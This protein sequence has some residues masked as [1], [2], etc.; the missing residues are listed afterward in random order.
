MFRKKALSSY[1]SLGARLVRVDTE[2]E[3]LFDVFLNKESVFLIN[4]HSSYPRRLC[5]QAKN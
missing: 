4:Y 3:G 1:Q 2:M 5:R